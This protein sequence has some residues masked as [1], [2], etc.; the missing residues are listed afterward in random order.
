MSFPPPTVPAEPPAP[1]KIKPGKGWYW[2]GSIVLA[3]GI[4]GAIAL[5][6]AGFFQLKST[7]EDFGRFR[8][9]NGTGKA[10]VTFDKPGT[11][12]IYYEHKSKVCARQQR[13]LHEGDG[14]RRP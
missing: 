12:S 5:G 11:Y 8:V 1:A 14:H 10:T 3:A 2:V 4:L 9:E 7:V 6:L 13:R